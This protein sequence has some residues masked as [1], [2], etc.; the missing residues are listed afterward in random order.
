[1][2]TPPDSRNQGEGKRK[3]GENWVRYKRFGRINESRFIIIFFHPS[4]QNCYLCLIKVM[5]LFEKYSGMIKQRGAFKKCDEKCWRTQDSRFMECIRYINSI[6]RSRSIV[7]KGCLT[8]TTIRIYVLLHRSGN[9]LYVSPW[10]AEREREHRIGYKRNLFPKA[11]FTERGA[12][13]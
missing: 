12:G 11:T 7:P 1:M 2:D 9:N 3:F 6:L 13:I 8:E 10:M 5:R 4:Y